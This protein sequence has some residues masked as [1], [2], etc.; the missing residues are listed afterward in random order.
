MPLIYVDIMYWHVFGEDLL[1]FVIK[2]GLRNQ[3]DDSYVTRL[4][5]HKYTF[6]FASLHKGPVLI[7]PW[8]IA[9]RLNGR[10][11]QVLWSQYLHIING[12]ITYT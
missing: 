7:A 9:L 11:F 3:R 6:I 2:R 10:R 1:T 8:S 4:Y 5:Q 12:L